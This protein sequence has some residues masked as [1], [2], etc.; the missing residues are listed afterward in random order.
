MCFDD[1]V[2]RYASLALKTVDVLCEELEQ[3]PL[4]MQEAD[5]G[6]S[7]G[8]SVSARKQLLGKG[9]EGQRVLPEERQ[10]EDGFRMWQVQ[11]FKVRIQAGLW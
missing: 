6:V 2:P 4:L 3:Q 1:L 11:A 8:R 10:L 5:E 9:I 7:Y